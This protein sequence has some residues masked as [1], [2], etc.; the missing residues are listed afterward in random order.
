[1]PRLVLFCLA[2]LIFAP[3]IRAA[4]SQKFVVLSTAYS[5]VNQFLQ[6]LSPENINL[7]KLDAENPL[8]KRKAKSK[9]W[10]LLPDR[11]V[12]GILDAVL[13]Q[14]CSQATALACG[15]V[16]FYEELPRHATTGIDTFLRWAKDNELVVLHLVRANVLRKIISAD[17]FKVY[18]DR[19]LTSPFVDV[20]R[21]NTDPQPKLRVELQIDT[22]KKRLKSAV[23]EINTVRQRL[24]WFLP[25]ANFEVTFEAVLRSVRQ[26]HAAMAFLDPRLLLQV[27]KRKGLTSLWETGG[28]DVQKIESVADYELE[29]ANTP[30]PPCSEYVIN[31]SEFIAATYNP[32]WLSPEVKMSIRHCGYPF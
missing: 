1:M 3:Q 11:V 6:L 9:R 5:G 21:N 20:K 29:G 27:T 18:G 12:H 15:F 24:E 13:R 28:A 4:E 23:N 17:L 25:G 22:I 8:A 7:V 14:R 2:Q 16:V 10:D 26:A 30:E 31:W 32:K 19:A